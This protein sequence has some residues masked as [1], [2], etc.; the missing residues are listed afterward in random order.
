MKIF[1]LLY[2]FLIVNISAQNTSEYF[3]FLYPDYI[4][5]T[6]NTEIVSICS[7]DDGDYDEVEIILNTEINVKLEKVKINSHNQTREIDFILL[8]D[9]KFNGNLYSIML[10]RNDHSFVNN[11]I[12]L[13]YKLELNDTDETMINFTVYYLK[14]G[15]IVKE[16]SSPDDSR[17]APLCLATYKPQKIAP[18]KAL[19]LGNDK[20]FEVN[21][22]AEQ[23]KNLAIEFWAQ[24]NDAEEFLKIISNKDEILSLATNKF[25]MLET[26]NIRNLEIINSAFVARNAWYHFC[27]YYNN[28]YSRMDIYVNQQLNFRFNLFLKNDLQIL[29]QNYKSDF[30]IDLLRIWDWQG[31]IEELFELKNYKFVSDFSRVIYQNTFDQNNYQNRNYNFIRSTAPIFSQAPELNIK[32]YSNFYTLQWESSEVTN[33]KEYI[34]EKSVDGRNFTNIYKIEK[35]SDEEK[36]FTYTDVKNSNNKIVYYRVKQ[37][38]QDGSFAYSAQLKIGQKK[39]KNF[40]LDQNFPN[41]F[42]PVTKISIQLLED[43]EVEVIVYNIVGIE[44]KKLFKGSL[45]KGKHNFEFDGSEFPSGIY[46]LEVKTP[47]SS[48]VMKMILAK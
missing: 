30:K 21:V 40:V 2:L 10:N 46:L 12:Q 32:G 3:R 4:P 16:F 48:E 35:Y 8:E 11:T 33:I 27:V 13:T 26:N 7:F 24:L 6:N 41:P 39:K 34:L 36:S 25:R 14:K 43:S 29:F 45:V 18:G 17:F 28:D 20:L 1:C 22:K 38:N 23:Y 44:I 42:N 31:N 37:I 15:E 9:Y 47:V 5:S 19:K